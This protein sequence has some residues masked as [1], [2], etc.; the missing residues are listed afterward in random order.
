MEKPA[1]ANQYQCSIKTPDTTGVREPAA[2][3][4]G[5]P[6][7]ANPP[8]DSG[9]EGKTAAAQ[10]PTNA[11]R[12]PTKSGSRRRRITPSTNTE[13][14]NGTSSAAFPELILGTTLGTSAISVPT[15]PGNPAVEKPGADHHNPR[16]GSTS[17][18]RSRAGPLEGSG[19]HPHGP[20]EDDQSGTI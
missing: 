13:S 1:S 7:P 19:K 11:G 20:A 9:N 18:R 2:P 3:T 6:D 8:Y 4:P 16:F 17:G 10:A 14:P 15:T 5:S 12:A